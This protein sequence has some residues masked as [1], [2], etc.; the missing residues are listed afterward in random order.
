M[1]LPTRDAVPAGW[2][3]LLELKPTRR[4]TSPGQKCTHHSSTPSHHQATPPCHHITH[5]GAENS[6]IQNDAFM[7]ETTSRHHLD[8]SA[9]SGVLM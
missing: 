9:G 8:A 4:H 5:E 7:K 3:S 2:S 6:V 1:S